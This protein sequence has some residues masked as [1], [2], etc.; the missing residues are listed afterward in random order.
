MIS[1]PASKGEAMRTKLAAIGATLLLGAMVVGTTLTVASAGGN[2]VE[3][4]FRAKTTEQTFVDVGEKGDSLGDQFIFHDVLR[5]AGRR[6][7]FDGGVCTV[8]SMEGPASQAQCQVTAWLSEGQ[9]TF[10][11]LVVETGEPPEIV[12]AVT[13]GTGQYQG[14]SGE[15]HVIEV[16]ETLARIIVHLTA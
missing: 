12:L 3:L 5:Q 9:I 6:V 11:G 14:A 16:S 2:E 10:Q 7:G 1:T 4:R 13:G 8:T 15:V